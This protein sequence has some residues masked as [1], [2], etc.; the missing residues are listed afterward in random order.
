MKRKVKKDKIKRRFCGYCGKWKLMYETDF[1]EHMKDCE[2]EAVMWYRERT[3][4]TKE[5]ID[6]M[7]GEIEKK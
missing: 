7:G 2:R 3:K 6:K 1:N 5:D 4:I